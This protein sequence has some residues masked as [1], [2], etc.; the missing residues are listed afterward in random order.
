[1]PL[2]TATGNIVWL[3]VVGMAPL[4]ESGRQSRI[5]MLTIGMS[6]SFIAV[7]F[8]IMHLM[9]GEILSILDPIYPD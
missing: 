9:Y 3:R 2:G 7:F 5:D 1:V 4:P 6:A 8:F